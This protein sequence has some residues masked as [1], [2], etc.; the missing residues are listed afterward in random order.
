LPGA[1]RRLQKRLSAAGSSEEQ[2]RALRTYSAAVG[3]ISADLRALEPPPVLEPAHEEQLRRLAATRRLA[4]RLR[5]ALAAADAEQVARLLKRF[6]R[7]AAGGARAGRLSDRA[8]RA[9][10][11]RLRGVREAQAD[12][13]REQKRLQARLG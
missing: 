2:T 12:I 8:L 7:T 11:R 5:V 10:T 6:R 1:N 13:Q 3:D 9:Y 4:D